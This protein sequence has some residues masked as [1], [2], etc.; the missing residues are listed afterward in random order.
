MRLQL[1]AL[2][3]AL[4]AMSARADVGVEMRV[5]GDDSTEN[6]CAFDLIYTDFGA[7]Y[8]KVDHVY[9]V[10]AKGAQILHCSDAVTPD[11]VD[12]SCRAVPGAK[13]DH[14]CADLTKVRPL[15]IRCYDAAGAET[16][17]G[18]LKIR[19]SDIFTFD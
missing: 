13:I 10:H 5:S 17:C 15:A 1:L 8:A 3:V 11:Y 9:E 12:T 7:N 14:T 18:P 16:P 2:L 19:G 6:S 4:T